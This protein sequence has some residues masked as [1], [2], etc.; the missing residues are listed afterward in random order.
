[1]KPNYLIIGA[2]KAGT[3]T[4]CNL[5]AQ[6]SEIY[7][8][9]HKETHF[10]SFNYERG[11]EWYESKFNPPSGV[12]AIGEGS[13]S[14]SEGK[15]E[16]VSRIAHYLPEARLIYIVRHPLKRIE[17][18]FVQQLDNG[19][20][21]TSLDHAIS[22]RKTLVESSRYWSRINEFR[23]YFDDNQILVLFMEDLIADS[24][25]V[26]KQCCDFL[27]IDSSVSINQAQPILNSRSSKQVDY[28]WMSWLR[29]QKL[30]LDAK[31]LMP[32]RLTRFLKPLLRKPLKVEIQWNK[33]TKQKVIDSLR[34]D[35][36]KFL[37]FYGKS[38]SYWNLDE[39]E[40]DDE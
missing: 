39:D 7:M 35:I 40:T 11:Y 16:V 28:Q 31:W 29:Q 23:Q 14:Y 33:T 10:F 9:P 15:Q 24:H 1:M 18:D 21:F 26:F 20:K 27:G 13:P 22:E 2:A 6:H 12:K 25:S 30:F 4:L 17:S 3:T 19:L 32:P 38:D 8:F 37:K 36:S 34:E 5:L